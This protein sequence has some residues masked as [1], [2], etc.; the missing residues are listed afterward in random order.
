ERTK[1]ID[2]LNATLINT[3]IIAL[4]I[5][6]LPGIGKT[7]LISQLIRQLHTENTPF[8]AVAWQSLQSV[9]SKAPPFDWIIDSLLFTLS[10][11]NITTAVTAQD[12]SLQ[13]IEKLIK[14]LKTKPCLICFDRVET[15]LKTK[16]AET[17][18]YFAEDC[19]EYAWLFK[20]LTET[21]HQSK[22]ILISRETLA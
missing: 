2:I 6:G 7:S 10:N 1:E 13:K 11:G 16:Q 19:A 18:G 9:T 17:A 3:D 5:I 22:I 15:L 12:N 14:I 21:E 4:S 8:T 20:Q